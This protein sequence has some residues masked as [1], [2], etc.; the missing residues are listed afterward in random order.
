MAGK[1]EVKVETPGEAV[2]DASTDAVAADPAP[3]VATDAP[4]V[5]AAPAAPA[6]PARTGGLPDA[7]DIDPATIPYGKSVLTKQGHVCSTAEDPARNRPR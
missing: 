5:S 6:A 1:R 3:S 7:D 2:A 4:E